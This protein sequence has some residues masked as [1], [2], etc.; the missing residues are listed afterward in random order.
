ML[1]SDES[2]T[3]LDNLQGHQRPSVDSSQVNTEG[4]L[5]NQQSDEVWLSDENFYGSQNSTEVMS[6]TETLEVG[7]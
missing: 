2:S 1:V 7:Y 5:D 6:P 4:K 3:G